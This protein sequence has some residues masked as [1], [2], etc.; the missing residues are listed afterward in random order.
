MDRP[1]T[2][3]ALAEDMGLRLEDTTRLSLL[4]VVLVVALVVSAAAWVWVS[5]VGVKPDFLAALGSPA[6]R[7]VA[8][9]IGVATVAAVIR[10]YVVS[11]WPVTDS[12]RSLL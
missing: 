6:G 12:D 2:P 4:D 7:L 3:S 10:A 1:Q 8:A 11:R 5:L 9:L